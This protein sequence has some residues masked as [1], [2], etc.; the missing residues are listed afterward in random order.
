M[1]GETGDGKEIKNY[2]EEGES[3]M[4]IDWF[5]DTGNW[6]WIDSAVNWTG[7]TLTDW[8]GGGTTDPL[9]APNQ[10]SRQNIGPLTQQGNFYPSNSVTGLL[11]NFMGS[12]VSPWV[13]LGKNIYGGYRT[14]EEADKYL[15]NLEPLRNLGSEYEG[16]MS[17]Y[18]TP[19]NLAREE[20]KEISRLSDLAAPLMERATY[21]GAAQARAK[22]QPWGASTQG[23][24]AQ[25]QNQREAA[26]LFSD[27]I[28]PR[29]RQ[30]VYGT[31]TTLGDSYTARAKM[32]AGQPQFQPTYQQAQYRANPWTNALDN[33]LF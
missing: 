13:D 5:D 20:A 31:G 33:Y 11:S 17:Q 1:A 23:N 10:P 32:M 12:D 8:F 18:Y 30:N 3:I 14:S 24:F 9:L 22:G 26:K 19:Q 15:Q 25:Q 2:Y 27:V 21:R 4:A 29:A 7:D 28:Q 6:D 16:F